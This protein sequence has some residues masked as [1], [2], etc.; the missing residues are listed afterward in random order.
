MK[1]KILVLGAYGFLGSSL[2]PILKKFG[3]EIIKHGRNKESETNFNMSD[4]S[5][6]QRSLKILNPDVIINLIAFTNVDECEKNKNKAEM[7]NVKVVKI[8]T[9]AIKNVSMKNNLHLIHISTD[10]VYN[11][12]GLHTEEDAEPI[13]FYGKSKYMGEKEASKIGSTILRVNFIGKSNKAGKKSLSDWIVES[14]REKKKI[15]VFKDVIFSPLHI[16]NLCKN[17]MVVVEKQLSGIFNL[18]SCNGMSKAEFAFQL[19]KLLNLDENLINPV[20]LK[21]VKLTA[22]RPL[23]MQMNIKKYEKMFK[24]S[25]DDVKEQIILTANDYK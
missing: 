20:N 19:S 16:S 10:Q 8:L 11:G 3:F 25:L 7:A 13:N 15:N 24:V 2:C 23:N 1:K 9:K 4:L 22:D 5:D 6:V 17:I 18:G 12:R 21:Q 14:L